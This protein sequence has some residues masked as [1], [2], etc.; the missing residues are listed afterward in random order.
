[1]INEK[2]TEKLTPFA[3]TRLKDGY[4]L[5]GET[6]QQ[7]F[8]RA[9]TAFAD[10]QAH[11]ER[12]YSYVADKQ[13][14][15]FATPLLS[16]GGTKRGLPISCFLNHVDDSRH[17]IAEHYAENLW[18]S[19]NGGGIGS[20]W[21]A[22]RSVG[23]GTSIGN[24]T[25][26][27]VPFLYGAY[28]ISLASNQGSTRRGSIAFYLDI[29]HPEIEEFIKLR[30]KGG[31]ETRRAREGHLAVNI[32]DSFMEAVRD[33]THWDLIDP[34]TKQV[35]KTVSARDLWKML[36]IERHET[37]EPF[38]HWS[39]HSNNALPQPLKDLGLRINNSNLCTEIMLPTN[40]DRTAVCCLSSVNLE[41]FD[42]WQHD[43][44]FIEDMMRMLDNA[45]Q[46]FIDTA[47]AYMWRA[48]GSARQER[49]VGLGAMGL[50]AYMQRKGIPFE[51][52]LA[53]GINLRMFQHIQ[54]ETEKASRKLAM[55]RGEAPD[56]RGTG[57]RFAHTTAIAPNA[58][59]AIFLNTS[60]G[61]ECF[62][63]NYFVQKTLSGSFS[64]KNKVLDDV[65]KQKY[66]LDGQDLEDA[67]IKVAMD[68]GSVRTLDFLS[69]DD[70]LI[71]KTAEEVS[72]SWVIRLAAERQKFID[73]GQSLNLY[74]PNEINLADWSRLH[75]A[76][77]EQGIK[78]LYYVRT[79][80][81]A[82]ADAISTDCLA[83][84]G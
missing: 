37:G 74:V 9:S 43:S 73:Q 64:V 61:I 18:L 24:Q 67:W 69:D 68:K 70:K 84:E 53:V 52:A 12:L 5:E 23:T 36:L 41:K 49:S 50:H 77:W 13:W 26:G 66:G 71:F 22:V 3:Q 78:S 14:F 2:L 83:C 60:P 34:H 35:K 25:T 82:R 32:S 39:D 80:A 27:V 15:M 57:L 28:A 44:Q 30:A 10:D 11:A 76:A 55:E 16:N 51:S 8:W 7:A 62:P 38:I 4:C 81:L 1:M 17:G 42:E 6:I 58:S 20:N 46:V 75:F 79:S 40:K 33:G 19:T 56:M 47:P 21:S 65:L 29:S 63:T 72:Q 54:R 31:I 59:S 48:I 45:L